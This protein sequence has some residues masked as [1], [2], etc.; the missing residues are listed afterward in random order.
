MAAH[1]APVV[2]ITGASSGIGAGLAS[3]FHARGHHVIAAAR[4]PDR[5]AELAGAHPGLQTLELDVSDPQAVKAAMAD[6]ESTHGRLDTVINNAGIQRLLDFRADRLPSAQEISEEININLTALITVTAAALPLLYAAPRAR[7]INVSSGLGIV[8]LTAAPIYS[9]TKAAVRSFTVSLR[10]QL[11]GSTVRVID[12]VPPVVTTE[13]HRDQPAAPPEA[14]GLDDF[15]D[16]AMGG[17]DSD[18]TEIYVGLTRVL[19]L[20]ARIAPNRF[21]GIVNRGTE[22]PTGAH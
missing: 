5:L 20:G 9:A 12:L 15:L 18:K 4:R 16:A 13:L 2:L 8:P 10:H 6:L 3:R 17:L 14:M 22:A 7:L 11:A 21:L 19:R 1:K